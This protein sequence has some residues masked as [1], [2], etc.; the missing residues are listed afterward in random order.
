MPD[1]NADLINLIFDNFNNVF[2]AG[3]KVVLELRSKGDLPVL[4]ITPDS[5][6]LS[7]SAELAIMN[8][9]NPKIDAIQMQTKLTLDLQPVM[10]P[11]DMSFTGTLRN[12][13]LKVIG[14][15]ALYKQD[16]IS[17]ERVDSA[18]NAFIDNIKKSINEGI[19]RKGFKLP[20]PDFFKLDK[21]TKN[22]GFE[23]RDGYYVIKADARY[24]ADDD[25]DD[26]DDSVL[27]LQ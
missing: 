16:K 2:G 15:K 3:N 10:Q 13:T 20:I 17:V 14:V 7:M 4:T 19:E 1:L 22:R 9:L 23:A 21:F 12:L 24:E 27:F 11:L 6:L 5:A 18:I 26:D 25:D 8:P